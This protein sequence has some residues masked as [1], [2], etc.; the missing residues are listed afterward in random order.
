MS[1]PLLALCLAGLTGFAFARAP[2]PVRAS[3]QAASAQA[4][5]DAAASEARIALSSVRA[6]A[7][8]MPDS[9]ER[10]ELQARID[11][12]ADQLDGLARAARSASAGQLTALVPRSGALVSVPVD[13]RSQDVVARAPGQGLP[14]SSIA[15]LVHALETE[16]FADGRARQLEAAA[17]S[18]WFTAAQ[19]RRL[20]EALDFSEERVNAGVLLHPRVVDPQN[21]DTVY[22][23]FDFPGDADRLRQ[24]LD[25][26]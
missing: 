4:D 15:D 2:V 22:G 14:A 26:P 21:W 13:A 16:A 9:P 25:L 19:V 20:L 7:A 8:A 11:R 23:A 17:R 6:A 24:Q 3:T 12:L 5:V 1:A 18:R 10:D